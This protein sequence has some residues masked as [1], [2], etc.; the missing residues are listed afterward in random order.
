MET[1]DDHQHAVLVA[2]F[3][4]FQ[5]RNWEIRIEHVYRKAK[6]EY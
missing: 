1:N 5:T 6:G 2:R 4:E 3:K